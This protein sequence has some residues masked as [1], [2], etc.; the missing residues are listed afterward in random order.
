MI[1]NL[2]WPGSLDRS[3]VSGA[4]SPGDIPTSPWDDRRG[5]PIGRAARCR[6]DRPSCGLQ[7]CRRRSACSCS[8]SGPPGSCSPARSDRRSSSPADWPSG[9]RD[10]AESSDG[11]CGSPRRCMTRHSPDRA[12]L[13]DLERRDP[14]SVH[15]VTSSSRSIEDRAPNERRYPP[16]RRWNRFHCRTG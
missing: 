8:S 2:G 4:I 5:P 16:C 13:S 3:S 14:G 11:S 1:D 15:V 10:S 7:S 12:F 9:P 6:P